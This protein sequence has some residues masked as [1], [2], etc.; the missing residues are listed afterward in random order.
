MPSTFVLA[1][2]RTRGRDPLPC[3]E[4]HATGRNGRASGGARA[5]KRRNGVT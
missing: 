3:A 2:A 1:H 5:A 4:A